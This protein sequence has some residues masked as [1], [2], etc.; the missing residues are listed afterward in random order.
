MAVN[1]FKLPPCF[2]DWIEVQL[3]EVEVKK[4]K[5]LGVD[6]LP[7][8]WVPGFH[9]HIIGITIVNRIYIR[10]HFL[11][12]DLHDSRTARLI[13]HELVHIQQVNRMG[14]INFLSTYLWHLRN[15]YYNHPFEIEARAEEARIYKLYHHSNP[16]GFSD[17]II[18]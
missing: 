16:C 11:P 7:F 14:A 3:P 12:L 1:I 5:F 17:K 8:Q 9:K 18:V 10:N 4:V 2:A 6:N 15:G 13:I